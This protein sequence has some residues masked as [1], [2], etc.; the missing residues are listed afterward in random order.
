MP[1]PFRLAPW[2]GSEGLTEAMAGA[3]CGC[4][5]LTEAEESADEFDRAHARALG[6]EYRRKWQCPAAGYPERDAPYDLPDECEAARG[7]VGKLTNLPPYAGCPLYPATMPWVH[8]AFELWELREAR[9]PDCFYRGRVTPA[10]IEAVT[11][12]GRGANARR[13]DDAERA[14]KKPPE[15]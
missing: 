2:L 12:V 11:E 6:E 5:L 4:R 14:R 7:R 15:P 13:A 8:A 9:S 3:P 1:R 10:L